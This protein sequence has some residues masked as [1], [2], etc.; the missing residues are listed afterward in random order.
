MKLE[1][2]AVAVT[3][4]LV[5]CN[6]ARESTEGAGGRPASDFALP[7]DSTPWKETIVGF[8]CEHVAVEA[9]CE[10]DWCRIPAGCFVKGSPEG[11]PH[12]GLSTEVLTAVT[13]THAFLMQRTELTQAQWGEL[14]ELN[15]SGP[16]PEYPTAPAGTH[17]DCLQP[18]C[19][20]GN[21]NWWEAA[22][23]ANRLSAKEG[24]QQCY[25]L[26][27]CHGTVGGGD[28][29]DFECETF[30]QAT[31]SIY[32]CGGYR[33]PTKVEHEY[34]A[35][36]GTRTAYYSGD[37]PDEYA[38]ECVRL[39][40]QLDAIGWYC[41]NAEDRTHP[42]ASKMANR[43]GLYDI[44]GNAAEW[45]H[46]RPVMPDPGAAPWTDPFGETGN[47]ISTSD[48]HEIGGGSMFLSPAFLRSAGRSALDATT[49]Y[50]GIGIRLVRSLQEG[51]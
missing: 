45:R 11:E 42:V 3:L 33:L 50:P 6:G 44:L 39:L 8:E 13:M 18:N 43:W 37:L 30:E 27:G 2:V 22:E 38:E 9:Q 5:G 49:R 12:H 10:G 36:A 7:A 26:E 35:R 31:E 46:N 23:F 4:A 19:P 1:G 51:E 34:A 32:D 25:L 20:V 28:G 17:N 21:V 40:P 47:G 41:A 24:R 29:A 16:S 14:V 48:A 15:P